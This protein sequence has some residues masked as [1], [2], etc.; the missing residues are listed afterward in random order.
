MEVDNKDQSTSGRASK[1]GNGRFRE[2]D[3][4]IEFSKKVAS[5]IP[6]QFFVLSLDTLASVATLATLASVASLARL[7]WRFRQNFRVAG[8]VDEHRELVNAA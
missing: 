7:P 3:L 1:T 5:G 8:G 2:L 6:V 4:E